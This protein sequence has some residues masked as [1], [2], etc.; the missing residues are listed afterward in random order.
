MTRRKLLG[1]LLLASAAA[2][3]ALAWMY[4]IATREPVVHRATLAMSDWPLGARPIRVALLSDIH[5][6]GPDMPP[7]RLSRIVE[8]VNRLRPDII[9]L[10][11]DFVSD[12]RVATRRFAAGD[13]LAPLRRLSAPLGTWAV[14]GNHDHWR[15]AAESRRALQSANVRI[16]DNDAATVGPLRL[17]GVDDDFTGN[18]DVARTVLRMRA[19]PGSKLLL[20]HSPDVAPRVPPDVTLV[21]AGHTHCGQIRLPIAGALSYESNFGDRYGC[22]LVVEGLRRVVITAG[23]GTSVLPIRFGAP[24]DMWLLTLGPNLKTR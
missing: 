18:A 11:G 3:L 13:G 2:L 17:G 21:V 20:T 24:P 23:L 14:L 15:N 6:A 1:F 4:A 9:L 10:A 7:E 5:V 16:L 19:G 12:K 22:G 8:Q